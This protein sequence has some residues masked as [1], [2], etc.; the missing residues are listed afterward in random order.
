MKIN[1][2]NNNQNFKGL[3]TNKALLKG[4]EFVSEHGTSF[5]AGTSLLMASVVRPLVISKTPDV[6]KENKKYLMANSIVSGLSKFAMVEAIAIPIENAVKKIDKN[7]EKFINSNTIQTL[8]GTAKNLTESGNYKFATQVLKL[9]AGFISAIPKSMLTIALIPVVMDKFF[10]KKQ[11]TQNNIEPKQEVS[12]IFEPIHSQKPAFKGYL[13]DI[14]AKGIGKIIDNNTFQNFVKNNSKNAD[15]IARNMA[16]A[17]D[18]LLTASFINRTN[19]SKKIKEEKKKPLIYNSIISTGASILGGYTIDKAVK[20]GSK[21]LIENFS[22]IH[23]NNPKLPKYIEGI[24]IVRP[25]LI[26]AGIYYGI[27]PLISTY[28]ADK[29]DKF[30][31]KKEGN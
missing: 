27:L 19:K 9:S 21:K 29:T 8:K 10:G 1:A 4:L 5:I 23:K 6:D 3:M 24:N 26:F 18:V 14:A 31:S 16:I 17:T 30:I 7:P 2:V 11:K 12:K 22:Q 13:S 15:N 25:T 20:K 28:L